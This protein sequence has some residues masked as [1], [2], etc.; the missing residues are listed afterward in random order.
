MIISI[1]IATYNAGETLARFLDS[2][3]AQK[4]ADVEILIIDGGSKDNTLS[5]ITDYAN[6]IDFCLSE[7]DKGI[8]DAW[9]KALS[10]VNGDWIMFLGADDYLLPNAL[11]YYISFIN[12]NDTKD[13]DIISGKCKYI[14][15]SG[16][17][18]SING[19]AY[20]YSVFKR[21]MNISHGSTLHNTRLF[22]ELGTFNLKY[23]ICAD[24]EFLMRKS[25]NSRF[26][27]KPIICM[28]TGGMSFS[29]DA[30]IETFQIR[31][32]KKVIS[33]FE[34]LWLFIRGCLSL[35]KSKI[36]DFLMK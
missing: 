2:I 30:L 20:N 32:E 9:N 1:V 11:N 5:I 27:D 36:K 12:D 15:Q 10:H 28:Q 34:N 14:D 3:I 19:S 25:L 18:L 13:V 6:K 17:L 31:R 7:K 21:Y 22:D 29:L 35:E 8:Y 24:Y 23:R 26:V 4:S 33:M 16:K